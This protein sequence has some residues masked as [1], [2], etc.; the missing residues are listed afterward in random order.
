VTLNDREKHNCGTDVGDDEQDLQERPE[1]DAG[2]SAG[3]DD[4][5]VLMQHRSVEERR[6]DRRD[7]RGD[8]QPAC[9]ASVLLRVHLHCDSFS[10]WVSRS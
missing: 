8:E 2:V 10:R 1:R 3:P 7:D 4:V 9:D 6:W 5:V